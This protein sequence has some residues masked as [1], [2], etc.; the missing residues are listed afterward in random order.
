VNVWPF[1]EVE[2][3]GQGNV[4]RTSELLEVSRAAYYEQ[5]KHLPSV[6]ELDDAELTDSGG[7]EHQLTLTV[8]HA[9]A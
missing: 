8:T 9:W 4:R 6:R 1:I 2:E 3:A 7:A 5:R